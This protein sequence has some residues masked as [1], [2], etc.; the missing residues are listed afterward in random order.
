MIVIFLAFQ[1]FTIGD[2]IYI[3]LS[4][5]QFEL[6]KNFEFSFDKG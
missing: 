2:E 4:L 1:I 6:Y 3:G 5:I